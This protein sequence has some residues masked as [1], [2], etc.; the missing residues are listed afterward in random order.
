MYLFLIVLGLHCCQ[1]FSLVADS[2]GDSLV[3]VRRLLIAVA[4]LVV[5]HRLWGMQASVVLVHGFSS[6][7]LRAPKCGLR[8]CGTQ[9]QLSPR[10]V[11]YQTRVR[12][13]VL[14]I[15]RQ[16]PNHWMTTEVL[17]SYVLV[18]VFSPINN[19][20]VRNSNTN[21]SYHSNLII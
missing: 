8:S 15:G 9:A 19:S 21:N 14:C 16:T 18:H 5:E 7:S 13:C 17:V 4:S 12:A 20:H 11:R 1:G 6:C 3:A 2:G 10:Q